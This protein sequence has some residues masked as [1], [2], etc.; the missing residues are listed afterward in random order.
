MRDGFRKV[1]PKSRFQ[2][3]VFK[4]EKNKINS[5]FGSGMTLVKS[6]LHNQ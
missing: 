6:W 1:Q 4:T 2:L 5:Y 3:K